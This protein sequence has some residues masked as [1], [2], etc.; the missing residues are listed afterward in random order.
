MVALPVGARADA[1]PSLGGFAVPDRSGSTGPTTT[2]RSVEAD[3]GVARHELTRGLSPA[4]TRHVDRAVAASQAATAPGQQLQVTVLTLAGAGTARAVENGWHAA[5]VRSHKR[6]VLER[7][8]AGGWLTADQSGAWLVWRVGASLGVVEVRVAGVAYARHVAE[9]FA[10]LANVSMQAPAPA[11]AFGKVLAEV[12]PDGSVSKQTAMQAFSLAYTPLPGVRVPTGAPAVLDDG[13]LAADWILPFRSS[14][15]SSQR[16]IVD[17]DLGLEGEPR[18]A[19]TATYGDPTF[20]EDDSLTKKVNKYLAYYAAQNPDLAMP[21]G[22]KVEAGR[23]QV[24]QRPV[25]LGELDLAEAFPLDANGALDGTYRVCRVSLLPDGQREETRRPGLVDLALAHEAFHCLQYG[26]VPPLDALAAPGWLKDGMAEWAAYEATGT[27]YDDLSAINTYI[28]NPGTP[29]FQREYDAVGFYGHVTDMTGSFF[30]RARATFVA[31]DQPPQASKAA[32]LLA[33]QA[34]FVAAGGDADPVLS[35]W[36]SSIFRLRAGGPA[37]TMGSPAVPPDFA[38]LKPGWPYRTIR[39]KGDTVWAAP[40]ATAQARLFVS[41]QKPLIHVVAS[42]PARML[43]RRHG[44]LTNVTDVWLRVDGQQGCPDGTEG[45]LPK[46]IAWDNQ[47]FIAITGAPGTANAHASIEPHALDEYCHAPP[48]SRGCSV[49]SIGASRDA[50]TAAQA[51]AC[52]TGGSYGDPHLTDFSGDLYDFQAAGEFTLLKS[53]T[54]DFEIQ[55]RQQPVPRSPHVFLNISVNTAAAMRVGRHAVE[56]DGTRHSSVLAY[57]DGHLMRGRELALA[58]GGRVEKERYAGMPAVLTVWPDGSIVVV[59]AADAP[60]QPMLYV[61]VGLAPGRAG[62]VEGLLGNWR[63]PPA[64]EFVGRNGRAYPHDLITGGALA[65]P[66]YRVL[67]K[68]FGASWRITQRESLFHYA[69]GRSTRSYT[70]VGFPRHPLTVGQLTRKQRAFG[71]RACKAITNP[72]LFTACVVD[73][74]AMDD[75]GL[76]RADATAQVT[77]PSLHPILLG[78]GKTTP[79]VAY[80]PTSRD[81]YVAWLDPSGSS[82]DLCTLT[83][84]ASKCNGG[85]GPERLVDLHT[86][87]LG[88]TPA[89]SAVRLVI[90]PGGR[91][92]VLGEVSGEDRSADPPGYGGGGGVVAWSSPAGG[93]AFA[94]PQQGIADTGILLAPAHGG[95]PSSGGAIVLGGSAIG[96]FGSDSVTGAYPLEFTDFTLAASAPSAPPGVDP[97]RDVTSA[98]TAFSSNGVASAPDPGAPGKYIVVVAALGATA[99]GCK[100]GPAGGSGYGV[101]VGTP[102]Q[103]QMQSAWS[104][105]YFRTL[106]CGPYA[107]VL[108]SGPDGIGLLQAAGASSVYYRRFDTRTRTFEKPVLVSNQS[109]VPGDLSV[110]QDAA[111]NVYAT[112]GDTL[113]D[114]VVISYSTDAGASWSQPIPIGLSASDDVTLAAA[115]DGEFLLAYAGNG[116]EYLVS[117]S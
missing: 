108:A 43:S 73:V 69:P 72:R 81:T 12:R 116:H 22:V 51:E 9:I 95:Q 45:D 28:V 4:L 94:T 80:D 113:A 74:G 103:L 102:A 39:D 59:Y 40:Y 70:V 90:E 46:T 38:A 63:V 13:T 7:V 93:S 98:D 5:A 96:V 33:D 105:E 34:A 44:E 89:F 77:S 82:I 17:R 41:D 78:A 61:R 24:P 23:S 53:T 31:G 84:S 88:V 18:G 65:T 101:G 15:T 115:G 48:P 57:V 86:I 112:W 109:P 58:G 75:P 87:A 32:R 6:P 8:G 30:A 14:L 67:Y 20:V 107:P 25:S 111:G 68:E 47:S 76:A 97:A 16:R 106:S 26:W 114:H 50:R 56:V 104:P 37:W 92:V 1:L 71:E 99:R 91:I 64:R 100:K 66:D 52:A 2:Y 11:T 55:V 79:Q 49:G 29:L 85:H 117:A 21:G 3:P 62:H 10:Q 19:R 35:S 83:P 110:S 42:P 27:P 60:G 54:D 36:G